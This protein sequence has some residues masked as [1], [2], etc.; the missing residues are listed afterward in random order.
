M[1]SRSI[2]IEHPS[3]RRPNDDATITRAPPPIAWSTTTTGDESG[4]SAES[5]A[6][7]RAGSVGATIAPSS[8]VSTIMEAAGQKRSEAAQVARYR[9]EWP[10]YSHRFRRILWQ[11]DIAV[12][13]YVTFNLLVTQVNEI[14][15]YNEKVNVALFYQY[16]Q[17]IFVCHSA[18]FLFRQIF[19]MCSIEKLSSS[20]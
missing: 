15:E 9:R 11:M 16:P 5:V 1:S 3:L 13:M 14:T 2:T 20:F 8:S 19:L 7:I 4:A 17:V 18:L 10:Q 6:A 12:D